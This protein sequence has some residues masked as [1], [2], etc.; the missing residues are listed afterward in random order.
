[1]AAPQS[2]ITLRAFRCVTGQYCKAASFLCRR[3]AYGQYGTEQRKE[4]VHVAKHDQ[5]KKRKQHIGLVVQIVGIAVG[6]A[7]LILD[8]V[9]R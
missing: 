4:V 2:F 9:A 5:D 1:M 7:R 8:A 3:R 6:V